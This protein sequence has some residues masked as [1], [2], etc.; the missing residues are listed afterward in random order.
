MTARCA[1]QR[2]YLRWKESN[3]PVYLA[4][5]TPPAVEAPP[6]KPWTIARIQ[7]ELPQV[8]VMFAGQPA[9]GLLS[10]GTQGMA[11]VAVYRP[12]QQPL[13]LT[14]TWP[15]VLHHLQ[16]GEAMGV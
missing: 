15:E 11:T 2:A 16:T 6:P 3:P 8:R 12:Y 4:P 9:K 7:A 1:A 10:R 5:E 14:F 13:V